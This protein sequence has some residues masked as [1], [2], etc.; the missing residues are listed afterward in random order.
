[1]D[2]KNGYNREDTWA[3][4]YERSGEE[5]TGE[6]DFRS[7]SELFK[8]RGM[9]GFDPKSKADRDRDSEPSGQ[10]YPDD[11]QRTLDLHGQTVS[12]AEIL[13][14]NFIGDC[15]ES[16]LKFVMVI[17]GIGRNSEGGVAKLRPLV[18]QKLVD[19][20]KKQLVRD[21]KTAELRHGGFGSIYIYLK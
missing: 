14:R 16:G 12:E 17:T 4:M 20:N 7:F 10:R 3:D 19:M 13:L 11:P 5:K 21:F 1:M 6:S 8:E 2:N 18:V 15:R 9:R